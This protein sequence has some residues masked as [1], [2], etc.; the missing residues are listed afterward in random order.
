MVDPVGK[1]PMGRTDLPWGGW[2]GACYWPILCSHGELDS[3]GLQCWANWD[4]WYMG[5]YR[6]VRCNAIMARSWLIR[7][8]SR[9]CGGP[10][11]HGVGSVGSSGLY[12]TTM[13]YSTLTVRSNAIMARQWLIRSKNRPWSGRTNHGVVGRVR[14]SG[15]PHGVDRTTMGCLGGW[16]LVAMLCSFEV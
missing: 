10:I 12:Y 14:D 8:E 7:S 15:S 6:N 1:L 3:D 4:G 2:E 16:V 9:P 13:G 11:F 5:C